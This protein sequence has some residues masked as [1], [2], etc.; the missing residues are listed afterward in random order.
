MFKNIFAQFNSK[1]KNFK[2]E[3]FNLKKANFKS[4]RTQIIFIMLSLVFFPLLSFTIISA[5]F[6]N[7]TIEKNYISTIEQSAER[8]NVLTNEK[9]IAFEGILTL[10]SENQNI[11]SSINDLKANEEIIKDEF[12]KIMSSN[13]N[14]KNVFISYKDG[15]TYFYP[16]NNVDV[17]V[18][19]GSEF[20]SKTLNNFNNPYWGNVIRD[21]KNINK[22]SIIVAKSVY[23]NQN[24]I[25]GII[26]FTLQ[27]TDFLKIFEGFI[28]D[29]IGQTFLV[30][31]QGNII[32]TR[33]TQYI[34]KNIDSLIKN[35]NIL[36][37]V[38][39]GKKILKK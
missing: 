30:D 5:S 6:L 7:K 26:G 4:V 12:K 35:K 3:K 19:K 1:I 15:T 32:T 11:K 24:N 39:S 14:I 29:N 33:Q 8:L 27:I 25:A 10:A 34:G 20:Y 9:F 18:A 13:I 2:L 21:K 37:E 17:N 31:S 36:K 38:I 16:S 22:A 28:A 23:D